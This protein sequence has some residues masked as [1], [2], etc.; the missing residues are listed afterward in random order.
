MAANDGG[1]CIKN[2][3]IILL[4]L[5]FFGGLLPPAGASV[6]YK[7]I[8]GLINIPS[9]YVRSS[10]KTG[11]GYFYANGGGVVAGN[12]NLPGDMELACKYKLDG[13]GLADGSYSLKIALLQEKILAPALAVGVEDLTGEERRAWY[14]AVSKQGPW[15]FRLHLGAKSAAGLFYGLEK[16]FKLKGDLR[17]MFPFIPLFTLMLEYDGHSFNY[18]VYARNSRGMRVDF[19]WRGFDNRFMV[20]V[21]KEF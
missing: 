12:V 21:Q 4:P 20:G 9:A 15:G 19:A 14:L 17:K 3:I 2:K 16:Q 11:V 6:N 5:L 18:G 8:D 7:G 13:C 1:R 10:W